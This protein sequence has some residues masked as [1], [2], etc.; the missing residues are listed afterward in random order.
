MVCW[1][2]NHFSEDEV[3]WMDTLPKEYLMTNSY[4]RR[5]IYLPDKKVIRMLTGQTIDLRKPIIQKLFD[6]VENSGVAFLINLDDDEQ[7]E[8]GDIF[9]N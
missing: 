3:E 9:V 1:K 6:Q 4:S 5:P 7:E 2:G 8:F